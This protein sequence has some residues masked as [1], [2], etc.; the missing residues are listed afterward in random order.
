MRMGWEGHV[1]RMGEE[2]KLKKVLVGKSEGE[3]ERLRGL[4]R[5]WEDKIRMDLREIGGGVW[6]GLIWLRIG[7][8]GGLL[9]TRYETSDS[10]ATEFD[11]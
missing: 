8:D 5:R 4:K 2:R 9:R 3:R 6:S 7:T 11:S 1:I 10:G